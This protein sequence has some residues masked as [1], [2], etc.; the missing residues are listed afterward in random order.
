MIRGVRPARGASASRSSALSSSRGNER[1]A[2]QRARQSR[3]VSR[4]TAAGPGD[5]G[6][7]AALG[8]GQ[9]DAGAEG[10]LLGRGMAPQEGVE[11]VALLVGQFDGKGLG[12]AQGRVRREG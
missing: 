8:G 5:P 4:V 11:G 7:A 2:I 10:D 6:V 3:T 9:D 12:S 1:K